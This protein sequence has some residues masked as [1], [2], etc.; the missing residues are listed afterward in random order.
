MNLKCKRFSAEKL[1]FFL[2][3]P[4]GVRSLKDRT[5]VNFPVN[6]SMVKQLDSDEDLPFKPL[7]HS[8]VRH[9]KSCDDLSLS[10]ERVPP[11]AGQEPSSKCEDLYQSLGNESDRRAYDPSM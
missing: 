3:L 1:S 9:E 7:P 11:D 8:R 6:E 10:L 4:S 2:G 5:K